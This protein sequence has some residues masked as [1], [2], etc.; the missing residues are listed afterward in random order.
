MARTPSEQPFR[1]RSQM[2]ASPFID[3]MARDFLDYYCGIVDNIYL[4]FIPRETFN[5]QKKA[6]QPI[7]REER[8]A[9]GYTLD[10]PSDLH[11]WEMG[12][13]MEVV[14]AQT[15][16]KNPE[17]RN[18]RTEEFRF[19]AE[20]FQRVGTYIADAIPAMKATE[21]KQIAEDM[22]CDFWAYGESLLMGKAPRKK[23]SLQVVRQKKLTPDEFRDIDQWFVRNVPYMSA[24]ASIP[25]GKDPHVTRRAELI[26]FFRVAQKAVGMKDASLRLAKNNPWESPESVHG[27]FESAIKGRLKQLVE[28]P[29][30]TFEDSLFSRGMHMLQDVMGFDSLPTS[31][32]KSIL[33]WEQHEK[34]LH[35]ALQIEKMRDA[36]LRVRQTGDIAKIS[37]MELSMAIKIQNAISKLQIDDDKNNPREIRVNQTINCVGGSIVGGAFFQEIGLRYVVGDL[38]QHSMLLLV[39]EDEH[40]HVVDMI[41][42]YQN[43]RLRGRNMKGATPREIVQF[44]KNP[45]NEGLLFTLSTTDGLQRFTIF[46]PEYGQK[47]QVL[48]NAGV[49]LF[50]LGS[51]GIMERRKS[52]EMS[53]EALERAAVLDPKCTE[54]YSELGIVYQNLGRTSEAIS[55]YRRAIRLD[56]S[57]SLSYQNLSKIF[58]AQ[59]KADEAMEMDAKMKS[60]Q[61][62]S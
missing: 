20:T 36:L 21:G 42:T 39:T 41:R 18:K 32:K 9:K 37:A 51:M 48:Y 23:V 5:K 16:A 40:V 25:K 60:M 24:L 15:F 38:P 26:K 6:H 53:R 30:I 3:P 33:R 52:L 12:G 54:I 58:W 62:S 55:C 22:A 56:P 13:V 27:K 49:E 4:R 61:K 29:R 11:L 44:S 43:A 2:E 46:G 19:L 8:S 50:D 7:L 31:V 34:T 35:Q 47:I 10:L 57:D 1:L 14:D 59:G 28:A 17:R 45:T